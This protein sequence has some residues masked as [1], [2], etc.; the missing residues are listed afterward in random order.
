M[1]HSF[2]LRTTPTLPS[3]LPLP[4]R[5]QEAPP[6][7]L[8]APPRW[9]LTGPFLGAGIRPVAGAFDVLEGVQA[10]QGCDH[11][12]RAFLAAQ[13]R[14]AAL[15]RRLTDESLLKVALKAK[16]KLKSL[17]PLDCWKI[18]DAG[19]Q[20]VADRNPGITKHFLFWSNIGIGYKGDDFY[21]HGIPCEE[22]QSAW[23]S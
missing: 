5:I 20:Q 22:G 2:Q 3:L 8:L 15:E 6:A 14:R 1:E 21:K 17:S 10:V 23:R 9:V 13:R 7:M 19:L 4:H 18:T 12:R 11:W 16:G